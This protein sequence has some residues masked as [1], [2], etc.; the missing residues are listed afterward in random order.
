MTEDRAALIDALRDVY[1]PCCA[2]RGISIVEKFCCTRPSLPFTYSCRSKPTG[3]PCIVITWTS[4]TLMSS[5]EGRAFDS[6]EASC[7]DT[8]PNV[9]T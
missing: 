7:V 6:A 4:R 5:G 9:F 2:D 8:R 1:D 3:M